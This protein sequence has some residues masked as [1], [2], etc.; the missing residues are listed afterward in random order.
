MKQIMASLVAMIIVLSCKQKTV[1]VTHDAEE[2][3][4]TDREFSQMSQREG[5]K[6]AFIYY[7]DS[8]VVLLR[9]GYF[10]MHGTDAMEYLQNINDSAF[11][12]TWSPE[13]AV[14]A[15]SG[16]LG[17]TYGLYTYQASDT[18]FQGTYVSIWQKQA[19]G[20]WK[21]ILDTGNPGVGKNK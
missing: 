8:A 19:D 1:D 9:S 16:D 14:M 6:K 4:K 2:I 15:L 17:Y 11:T 21:Y 20:N 3:M 10:P 7:A 18:T 12:L 13:N 5:M